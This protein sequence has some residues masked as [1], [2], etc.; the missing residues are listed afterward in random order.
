MKNSNEGEKRDLLKEILV[1]LR[2]AQ[3]SEENSILDDSMFCE[4]KEHPDIQNIL[5]QVDPFI[6]L[7]KVTKFRKLNIAYMS[8]EEIN[9]AIL[10]V[11][12]WN[13]I[14]SCYTN[15]R[16]Y[17]AGTKFFR[18]KKLKGTKI[19]N[20]RFRAYQD[21]WETNPKYLTPYGRLNKPGESLLYV[22]PDLDCCIDEVHIQKEELFAAIR[23]TAKSDVKVNMIGG[24][25]DYDQLGIQDRDVKVVNEIY[26]NFLRDEFSRDVGK[27][28]EYIYRVSEMIAKNYFDLPPRVVQDAWAYSSVQNKMKYNVCFRPDI[29]HEILELDGAMLCKTASSEK[30]E[31]LCVAV[32]ADENN[33]ILFYPLGSDQQKQAFPEIGQKV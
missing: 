4:L 9:K 12:C 27:G 30:V 23:Y 11:L 3:K 21:Y 1:K 19:P 26:N 14:A 10:D 25:M 5:K 31:V 6:L 33:N 7:Q 29:A 2:N 22:S 24:E 28:T 15:I 20:E 17:P 8:D 13:G 16:M 18:V 32:G